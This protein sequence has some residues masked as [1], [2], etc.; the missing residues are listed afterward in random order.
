MR[1][2]KTISITTTRTRAKNEILSLLALIAAVP[3][4]AQVTYATNSSQSPTQNTFAVAGPRS[5]KINAL[6]YHIS[7]T[8]DEIVYE[9]DKE[10]AARANKNIKTSK[11]VSSKANN[12]SNSEAADITFK[13]TSFVYPKNARNETGLA[14]FSNQ[15]NSRLLL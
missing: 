7:T 9:D 2:M 5:V 8:S 6:P 10:M 15:G 4:V 13:P 14:H 12:R 3:A 11:A 1:T